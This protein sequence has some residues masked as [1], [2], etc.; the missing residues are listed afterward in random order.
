MYKVDINNILLTVIEYII[1]LY[2]MFSLTYTIALTIVK[3]CLFLRDNQIKP[4]CS[5]E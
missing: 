4:Y 5:A 2:I 3:L 1:K